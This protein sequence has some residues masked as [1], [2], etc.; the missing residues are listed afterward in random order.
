MLPSNV[1]EFETTSPSPDKKGKRRGGGLLILLGLLIVLVAVIVVAV[2]RLPSTSLS[3]PSATAVPAQ[4]SRQTPV[5]A[6]TP[7]GTPA[8]ANTQRS[9]QQVI[10]QLDDAQAEAIATSNPNVMAATATPEF[11]QEQVATNQDLVDNGVTEV[12]LINIEWGDIVVNGTTAT[13]TAWETWS[14][15][16][17]DGTTMQARDRNVYTLV[18]QDGTWK[19]QSDDH[20]DQPAATPGQQPAAPGAGR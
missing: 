5:A 10:Q 18:Q 6:R 11:Y 19:V 17:E 13:A 3:R 12:K 1:S 4:T 8:D 7:A 2:S 20:P 15:T 16:F 9:I 14:T